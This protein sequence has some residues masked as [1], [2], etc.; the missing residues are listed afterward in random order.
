MNLNQK[1]NPKK[2]TS[3]VLAILL[4][5]I[6]ILAGI[7][8]TPWLLDSV[9]HPE[10]LRHLLL[11]SGIWAP[12]VMIILQ[13]IQVIIAPIPGQVIA[14]VSGYVFGVF[15][16][17]VLSMIGL[18][19]GGI[20]AFLLARITGRRILRFFLSEAMLKRFDI[21][22]LKQGPFVLFLLLLIPNPLGDG[23]YYLAGLT[24]IPL[25]FY[26][27]LVVVSRLPSNLVNNIIGA[28]VTYFSIYHWIVFG[29]IILILALLYY[30]FNNRIEEMLLRLA[31][32]KEADK[33]N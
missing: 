22:T 4:L 23:V 17:T 5:A 26:I 11:N 27:I 6:I 18:T 9:K 24:K 31:K 14:F 33:P 32:I 20:I 13:I 19:I 10:R 30:L 16:G 25:L 12:L 1:L 7:L 29:L 3:I 8:L 15:K 21:Y 2:I 28:K